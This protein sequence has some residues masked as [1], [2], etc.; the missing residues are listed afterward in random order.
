ME[1]HDTHAISA[2]ISSED[3]H[4]Y[5]PKKQNQNN[6]QKNDKKTGNVKKIQIDSKGQIDE[7]HLK[8][9]KLPKKK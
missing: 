5:T 1:R 8:N 3:N 7:K 6:N 9:I 2:T 4:S